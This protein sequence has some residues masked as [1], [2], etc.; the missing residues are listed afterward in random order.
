MMT[1]AQ[2]ADAVT[3][4]ADAVADLCEARRGLHRVRHQQHL[5]PAKAMISG[6]MAQ[7]F[8]R[9]SVAVLDAVT[10][11]VSS[12]IA[13]FREATVQ[14]KTFANTLLPVSLHPLRM[15]SSPVEN[16]VYAA[17]IQAVVTG[18]AE[19]LLTEL[20]S[21]ETIAPNVASDY[22]RNNSLT[23]LTGDIEP[24]TLN[25]LRNAVA[26][27]WDAG[28]SYDQIVGAI[29]DTFED[30]SAARADLIAQTEANA[31]YNAGRDATARAIGLD[32]KS[33][34]TEDDP[35]PICEA[36]EAE[37]WIGID[38]TFSSGDDM[39]LAHPRCS[40]SCNFR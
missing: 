30:F 5:T 11:H 40:C 18:A 27:A 38:D 3:N 9:Q 19:T 36:N 14:G 23:K 31:A 7:Y 28:G 13:Q 32:E 4:A 24:A 37:G 21:G 35:C 25:Q 12:A 17:A 20:G 1:E 22:L 15:A 34:E 33:W 6:V 26:D 16:S 10:P 8:G 29:R 2:L 39:P